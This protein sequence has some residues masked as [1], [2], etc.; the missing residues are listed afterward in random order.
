MKFW[1]QLTTK[2]QWLVYNQRWALP[3]HNNL[4]DNESLIHSNTNT[5]NNNRNYDDGEKVTVI[6]Y[7]NQENK[8]MKKKNCQ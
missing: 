5:T 6:N 8:T 3:A 4:D 7:S 2:A 1:A